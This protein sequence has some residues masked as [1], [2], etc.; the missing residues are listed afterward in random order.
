MKPN[1][2]KLFNTVKTSVSKHSPEILT[3][4]G[5]AGMVTTV[6]L[7]VKAT[8]KALKLIDEE[9]ERK[10]EELLNEAEKKH[11]ENC[12][13]VTKLTP[14]ETIKVAWK[15]YAPAAVTGVLSVACFVGSTSVSVRRQAA[16]YSVY[17]LSE[18]AYSEYR[19]KVKEEVGEE[20]EKVIREKVAEERVNNLTFHEEGVIHTGDGNTL[21]FDPISKTVFRS[22]QTY[23]EKAINNL[24]WKMTHG[25]EP[26]LSLGD[27]YE[28]IHLPA[29]A[30]GNEIGWRTDKGLI[31][32]SFPAAKTDTGEPC[33]SLEYLIPPQ[34]DFDNLY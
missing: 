27:F 24:N 4:I 33:L 1:V 23:I 11:Q 14:V 20:K 30:L 10:N 32:I 19:E 6:V 22:S 13:Q 9:I 28:E 16:L 25:N 8:P 5:I 2:T 17:K 31:D 15:P 12:G 34:W 7:A 18:T 26:Y 21:F 3:G 29:Y